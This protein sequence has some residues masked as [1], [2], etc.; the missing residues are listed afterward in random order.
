MIASAAFNQQQQQQDVSAAGARE[1]L[2]RRLSLE[3]AH[4]GAPA[5]PVASGAGHGVQQVGMV[6]TQELRADHDLHREQITIQQPLPLGQPLMDPLAPL[7]AASGLLLEIPPM[8]LPFFRGTAE[9]TDIGWTP[10][11]PGSEAAAKFRPPM[12]PR[13][14]GLI[15]EPDSVRVQ[16][17]RDVD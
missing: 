16:S 11:D 1:G 12:L 15:T 5:G 10:G 17:P 7:A 6:G 8:K 14:N 2:K 4:H 3:D 13:R 9:G